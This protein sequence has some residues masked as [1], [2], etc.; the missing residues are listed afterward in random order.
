MTTWKVWTEKIEL[1]INL[2][3][4]G[5]FSEPLQSLLDNI[6]AYKDVDLHNLYK[7]Q[8]GMVLG[9]LNIS[10]YLKWQKIRNL[11]RLWLYNLWKFN[12]IFVTDEQQK[13][14]SLFYLYLRQPKS[15]LGTKSDVRCIG[16]KEF[17]TSIIY[18]GKGSSNR[19]V[20]H[21]CD[22]FGDDR[23]VDFIF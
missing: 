20:D 4:K 8:E 2:S 11:K 9:E 6:G 5:V 10:E 18:V 1:N 22:A 12:K 21:I 17:V 13:T 19:P 16:F 14:N 3:I 15:V 7:K 23:K